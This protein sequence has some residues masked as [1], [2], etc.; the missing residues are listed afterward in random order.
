MEF[1]TSSRITSDSENT[2][3]YSIKEFQESEKT[4]NNIC[5]GD[6]ILVLV[7]IKLAKISRNSLLKC[8][9]CF[10]YFI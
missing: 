2:N 4:K 7:L 1:I 6:I 10:G 3:K 9:T 8:Q 5:I